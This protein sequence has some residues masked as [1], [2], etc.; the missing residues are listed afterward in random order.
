[1]AGRNRM[2]GGHIWLG[3]S[4]RL[5]AK[6]GVPANAVRKA[7]QTSDM[8]GLPR[9]GLLRPTAV[10]TREPHS[11]LICLILALLGSAGFQP[12]RLMHSFAAISAFRAAISPLTLAILASRALGEKTMD[13][14]SPV[15]APLMTS[16]RKRSL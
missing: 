2:R 10:R 14:V 16:A 7:G 9:S 3:W 1:M 4:D 5:G 13:C 12:I 6:L 15:K 8:Y 11:F